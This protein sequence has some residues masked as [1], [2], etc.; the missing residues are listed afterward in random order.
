MRIFLCLALFAGVNAVFGGVLTFTGTRCSNSVDGT[1]TAVLCL[2][3]GYINQSYG[4]GANVDVSYLAFSSTLGSSTMQ[5]W[6]SGFGNGTY[7]NLPDAAYGFFGAETVSISFVALNGGTVTLNSFQLGTTANIPR[8]ATVVIT[9]LGTNATVF[10]VTFSGANQLGALATL[11]SPGVS[12]ATGLRLSLINTDVFNVG[13]SNIDFD[14]SAA[15]SSAVPEPST[16][17]LFALTTAAGIVW[18]KRTAQRSDP[19]GRASRIL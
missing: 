19:S 12:S 14:A 4:D 1:G 18:R 17:A 6:P 10:T 2:P 9:D 16:F 7:S 13:I 11:V 3:G 5:A 8:N 15:Q